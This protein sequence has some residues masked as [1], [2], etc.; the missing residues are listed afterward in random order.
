MGS[1][2]S[3]AICKKALIEEI[4]KAQEEYIQYDGLYDKK[5]WKLATTRSNI[6]FGHGPVDVGEIFLAK[7]IIRNGHVAVE[8]VTY[9][10]ESVLKVCHSIV[11]MI[12]EAYGHK[13]LMAIYFL[14]V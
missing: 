14:E 3:L 2:A 10:P 9:D 13:D 4:K 12:D 8:I 5:E 1:K 7:S 6:R 11:D